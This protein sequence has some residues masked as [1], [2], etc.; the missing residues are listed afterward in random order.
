MPF[1]VKRQRNEERASPCE[2]RMAAPRRSHSH[3]LRLP[4]EE[5]IQPSPDVYW[6]LDRPS[7]TARCPQRG[8]VTTHF[9]VSPMAFGSVFGLR[10]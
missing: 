3:V 10:R 5:R 8:R 1:V 6:I 7:E 2:L 9:K 4:A